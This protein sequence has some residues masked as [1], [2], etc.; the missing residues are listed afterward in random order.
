MHFKLSP[1]LPHDAFLSN[2]RL[3]LQ[4]TDRNGNFE[5]DYNRLAHIQTP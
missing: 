5:N 4:R 2:H 3:E 1:V